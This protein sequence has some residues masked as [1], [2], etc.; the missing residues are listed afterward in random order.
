M[1]W[2]SGGPYC[3]DE[4]AG[5]SVFL[6]C[7][8]EGGMPPSQ[9][10]YPALVFGGQHGASIIRIGYGTPYGAWLDANGPDGFRAIRD[11]L[12]N[13]NLEVNGDLTVDGGLYANA[14]LSVA[15]GAINANADISLSAGRVIY[16]NSLQ[17]LGARGAAVAD[18]TDAASAIT[19][20]NALLARCRAH[21]LIAT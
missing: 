9:M 4:P 1:T 13:R 5:E 19:Q 18:A 10:N 2:E 21:G 17:V 15:G 6:G 14:G 8:S 16:N 3:S 20:L 11:F 12:V 7:Y